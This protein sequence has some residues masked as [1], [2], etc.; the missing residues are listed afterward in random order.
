MSDSTIE[1]TVAQGQEAIAN[2]ESDKPVF[3]DDE[4]PAAVNEYVHSLSDYELIHA[5]SRVREYVATM[6]GKITVDIDLGMR[7][8]MEMLR[9]LKQILV[10]SERSGFRLAWQNLIKIVQF[11]AG[12]CF[13]TVKMFRYL[14]H[15]KFDT[16][17]LEQFSRLANL[18]T[19]STGT[20]Y[21]TVGKQVGIDKTFELLGTE[22][23]SRAKA[24]YR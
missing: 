19:N 7:Q 20:D 18:L 1:D 22:A 24:F 15:V 14:D 12:T 4:F 8:Q 3:T 10:L 16:D 11:N 2:T 13:S 17:S 6:S 5:F 21:R 9:A 23:L